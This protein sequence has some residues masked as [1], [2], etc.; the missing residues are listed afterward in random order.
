MPKGKQRC[1]ENRL[2]DICTF[3]YVFILFVFT[4]ND[5]L[6]TRRDF[7]LKLSFWEI[8]PTKQMTDQKHKINLGKTVFDDNNHDKKSWACLR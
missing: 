6:S 2:C 3:L 4:T 1:T 7:F 8:E 5:I